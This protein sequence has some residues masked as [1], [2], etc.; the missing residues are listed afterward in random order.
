MILLSVYFKGRPF[1][2]ATLICMCVCMCVV[3]QGLV[4]PHYVCSSSIGRAILS[5]VC[6]QA[7]V[8]VEMWPLQEPPHDPIVH[9]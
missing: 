1:T 4:L 2:S 9:M 8:V 7:S 6:N 3:L 5:R